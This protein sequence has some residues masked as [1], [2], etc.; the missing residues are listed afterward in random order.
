MNVMHVTEVTSY[1]D[2][3]QEN[4]DISIIEL[5]CLNDHLLNV[6]NDNAEKENSKY[7]PFMNT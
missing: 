6:S 1:L 7:P 3:S 5:T 2:I 4:V